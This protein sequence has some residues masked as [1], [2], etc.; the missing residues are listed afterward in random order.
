MKNRLTE[1]EILSVTTNAAEETTVFCPP[2]IVRGP[3]LQQ[4]T[5]SS[6][7]IRWATDTAV[8]GQVRYSTER[9]KFATTLE[10][11]I[12]CDHKLELS[13]LASDR[14]YYY[15]IGS[16]GVQTDDAGYFV[17]APSKNQKPEQTR[18]LRIWVVGD[19][20]RGNEIAGLVRD[21][22]LK[23]TGDRHT[24]LW[25]ML[26][27][28]AYD[29]G[30]L[31][32][33]QR[34][35][36]DT[37]PELL[38]HSVL[39]TA[40]GNHD[41]GSANS[42]WQT[43]PYYELF[44]LPTD[45]EAGG[46]ASGTAAYYSFD[47]GNIHFICLDSYG[48]DRSLD[49]TMCTWMVRDAAASD[50]DWLVAFWHHPPYT[51]GSHDSDLELELIEMRRI[52]PLLE[53]AGVDLVL[54]GHSHAYERSYLI[55]GHYGFSDSFSLEMKKDGGSGREDDSGP[56]KKSYSTPHAGTVYIV[57]GTSALADRVMLHPAMYTSLSIPGSL[58][59]DVDGKRLDVKFIDEHG[60]VQDYFTIEK[61]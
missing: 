61:S 11:T 26:G 19:A 30:T 32:E 31:D 45:G 21:G 1:Y 15:S 8:R 20:G 54:G 46:V 17:T 44:T 50:K 22:Y 47:Y 42:L 39:W 53:D 59:L 35:V 37:Y 43:G 16:S 24:D 23:F 29:T 4:G 33:Y 10:E 41:A 28:N 51:K 34:G 6:I 52:L 18:P 60:E 49:G 13:G 48:S 25:L 58:V 27:D 14:K 2:Q 56:Y 5:D 9:D 55:D 7:V 36:F 12:T 40:I 57:A 3:Y 38:R